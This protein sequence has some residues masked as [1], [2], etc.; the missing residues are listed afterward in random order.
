MT[1]DVREFLA[2][3]QLPH[4]EQMDRVPAQ[5]VVVLPFGRAACTDRVAAERAVELADA[6]EPSAHGHAAISPNARWI[7]AM[8]S[9]YV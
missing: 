4:P 7:D 9:L 5:H 3:G 1:V 8:L 2:V 6:N